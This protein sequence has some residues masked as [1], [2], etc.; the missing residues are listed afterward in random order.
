MAIG[1]GIDGYIEL[2]PEFKGSLGV[3]GA[4]GVLG[5]APLLPFV[6]PLVDP[7]PLELLLEPADVPLPTLLLLP[8]SFPLTFVVAP[9]LPLPFPP[10]PL[11]TLT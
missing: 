8:P 5:L 11:P 1:W 9:L 10:L 2:K 3:A 4:G 6:L 7:P